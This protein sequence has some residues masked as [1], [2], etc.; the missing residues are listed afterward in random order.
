MSFT[1]IEKMRQINEKRFGT[2][3]GPCQPPL[4]QSPDSP[5]GLKSAALRFLHERCEDLLFDSGKEAQEANGVYQ[6][7]SLS[8]GQIP[9]NMQMDID[10][11]CLEKALE[12]FID[13]GVAEDAY[14][15]YYCYLE[16]FLGRYGRSKQMVELLSEYESNGSA[17]LM[18]H[19]DHYSHSVYVFALGLAIYE[20]SPWFRDVF[21]SFYRLDPRETGP[22]SA[23]NQFLEFWGL[24]ALFHD[25]GYPF[26][27]PFEQVLS[28]FEMDDQSRGTGSLFLGYRSVESLTGLDVKA[29]A[30]FEA[31]YGRRFDTVSQLL[32]FD[33]ARK[34]GDAY[35]FPEEYMRFVLDEKPVRPESF[36]YYMDHAFFSAARLYRELE[37]AYKPAGLTKR[38]VD[39]LS[40]IMLHNSLFKFSI[41]FYKDKDKTK[42]KA[43]L[44]AEF[45][46]L[47]WLLMLCNEL[48]C[49]D[50]TAYGRNSRTELHPMSAEFDFSGGAVAA[51]YY[52]DQEEQEKI[53]A[54]KARYAQWEADGEADDPPRLKAY[55]DMAE[56]ERRFTGDIEKIVDL[57]R[58]PL[59]IRPDVRSVDRSRKHTYLSD[60]SFLHLYDFS[61][62]LQGRNM[63]PDTPTADL[64][65]KFTSLS[66]EYQLSGINRAKSFSR[67]L[68]ALGCFYTDRPVDYEMVTAFGPE[69][70]DVI[71]PLEPE[72][73]IREHHAMGWRF[74]TAYETLPLAED[75]TPQEKKA[76]SALRE[77]LRCHRLTMDGEP[78]AQEVRDHFFSLDESDQDKDWKPFNS[79]LQLLKR[80]DGLRIYRLRQPWQVGK[81]STPH[82][83]GRSRISSSPFPS[84]TGERPGIFCACCCGG[85][86]GY[87]TA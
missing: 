82:T 62:A 58:L 66:L 78:T 25:I 80:F 41:C 16:M 86:S 87:G 76:R 8:A 71:A 64:E 77:Q 54:F 12:T 3:I 68:D 73:W 9:Y 57:S 36:G 45:H 13:S 65:K 63:P 59:D 18:K 52:Y 43:P 48:Q 47:A 22:E 35:G 20:T 15:V 40:A 49:W 42:R 29:Q 74:G 38:H 75:G 44:R 60:S 56:K 33:I 84:P 79:M 51:V 31:L 6:G 81:N 37:E 72:R 32:A 34:L 26:E 5:N 14:T 17:L 85:A 7:K 4:W 46:P 1:A 21:A 23:A 61:V 83:W 24:T 69:L 55:S 70:T 11:L 50:R 67:Y 30:H 19:R 53:D 27:L 10:R 2:D 39:A 28:Y